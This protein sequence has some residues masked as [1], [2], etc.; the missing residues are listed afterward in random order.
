MAD[1]A[2]DVIGG[3]APSEDQQQHQ[4]STTTNP[5][6]QDLSTAGSTRAGGDEG[7]RE[8][9]HPMFLAPTGNE[10][11]RFDH[12]QEVAFQQHQQY[13]HASLE[14]GEKQRNNAHNRMGF[15]NIQ[16]GHNQM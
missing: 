6:S 13:E 10:K 15:P 3:N 1:D 16:P 14:K 12:D 11:A 4:Q 9:A 2:R 5:N 8:I 7:G